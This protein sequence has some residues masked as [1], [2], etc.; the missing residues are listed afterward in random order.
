MEESLADRHFKQMIDLSTVKIYRH[1][2]KSK[3]TARK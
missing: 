1:T 2:G 3:E